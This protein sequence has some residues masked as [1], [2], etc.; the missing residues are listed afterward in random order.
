MAKLTLY[1][2]DIC[3]KTFE[4]GIDVNGKIGI[5]Y[6]ETGDHS[7]GYDEY[8]AEICS[9]CSH[10]IGRLIRSLK[11]EETLTPDEIEKLDKVLSFD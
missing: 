2:C 10:K 1:K 9:E 11:P 6:P 3:E 8:Y 5:S 4:H 7:Y